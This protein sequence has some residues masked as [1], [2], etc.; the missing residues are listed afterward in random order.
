LN[1]IQIIILKTAIILLVAWLYV[2][3]RISKNLVK[4]EGKKK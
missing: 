1:T 4:D 2:L 3:Y